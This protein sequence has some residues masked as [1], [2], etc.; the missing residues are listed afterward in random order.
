MSK[1][2]PKPYGFKYQAAVAELAAVAGLKSGP[3]TV[4]KQLLKHCNGDTGHAFPGKEGLAL[5][6]G[7]G[8]RTVQRHLQ[9]LKEVGLILAVGYEEGGR[10]RAT[11]YAFDLP[12]WST[13]R[14][15]SKKA[16]LKLKKEVKG[17]NLTLKEAILALKGSQFGP[18]TKKEQ[19]ITSGD[20]SA[21]MQNNASRIDK[22]PET[23]G[24]GTPSLR[25]RRMTELLSQDMTFGEAKYIADKEEALRAAGD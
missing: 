14:A 18:P 4:L 12:Q 8:E 6:T 10:G 13:P 19:R 16:R 2:D 1:S 25:A 24:A 7:Q 21:A 17:A 3:Q 22:G 23:G 15:T 9:F 11:C 20:A 5:D